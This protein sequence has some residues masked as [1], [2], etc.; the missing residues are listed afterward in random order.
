MHEQIHK[1]KLSLENYRSLLRER[2]ELELQG[3]SH[4]L[5]EID[6]ILDTYPED[7]EEQFFEMRKEYV[8]RVYPEWSLLYAKHVEKREEWK[9]VVFK[10]TPFYTIMKLGQETIVYAKK[11]TLFGLIFGRNPKAILAHH[12]FDA[13][14]EARKILAEVPA[15][16]AAYLEHFIEEANRP[17]NHSLYDGKFLE[18]LSPIIGFMEE[19]EGTIATLE[20]QIKK[21]EEER[22]PLF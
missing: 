22:A 15:K 10:L 2:E 13:E 14:K 11:R 8:E 16:I 5:S 1:I 21:L 20:A 18:L 17:W 12:L 7:F 4:R 3:A 19:L 6:R 9:K